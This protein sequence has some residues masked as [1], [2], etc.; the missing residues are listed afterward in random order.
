MTF[1][2]RFVTQ[3]SAMPDIKDYWF[4]ARTFGWGWGLPNVWQGW[5]VYGIGAA[6]F[7]AGFFIFPPGP[8]PAL[9]L[10]YISSVVVVLVAICWLK[11]EPP[12]WRW[13]K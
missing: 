11:G 4:P 1:I 9:F 8:N 3:E 13:G 6:L 2:L 7:V 10:I 5:L 12:S